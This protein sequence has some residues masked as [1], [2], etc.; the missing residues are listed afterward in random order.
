[1]D[2]QIGNVLNKIRGG[3]RALLSDI[4]SKSGGQTEN[5]VTPLSH[6]TEL[7]EKWHDFKGHCEKSGLRGKKG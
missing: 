5:I 6:Q 1:V 4:L 2:K 7:K 3:K